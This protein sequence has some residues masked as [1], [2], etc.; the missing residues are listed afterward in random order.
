[1]AFITGWPTVSDTYTSKYLT[2][3]SVDEALDLAQSAVQPDELGTA[4]ALDAPATGDAAADEVVVGSDTRLRDARTPTTH[5]H[6]VAVPTGEGQADGFLSHGDQ[7]KLNGIEAGATADQ[8][9]QE[10]ATAI[11]ADE[12]AETTLR[13]ALGITVSTAEGS[14]VTQLKIAVVAALP[15]SPDASTLYIVTGV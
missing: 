9:A 4:A 2:G 14:T 6:A 3:Q 1:M 13:S 15:G 8:T 10:I 7:A 12:T 5:S 11:D